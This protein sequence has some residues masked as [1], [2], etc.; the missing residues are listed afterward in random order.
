[1]EFAVCDIDCSEF[2]LCVAG[3][4]V[5]LLLLLYQK[6][7]VLVKPRLLRI[8]HCIRII[9]RRKAA[10]KR[11]VK[12]AILDHKENE[13]NLQM[14]PRGGCG[15]TYV[16]LLCYVN[17]VYPRECDPPTLISYFIELIQLGVQSKNHS[18]IVSETETEEE[19]LFETSKKGGGDKKEKQ[20]LI[21]KNNSAP[22]SIKVL[23]NDLRTP[24]LRN[25]KNS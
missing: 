7:S 13:G 4:G 11:K 22:S 15:H 20:S 14:F 8:S 10:K 5:A 18:L 23:R 21:P 3:R 17:N 6:V 1:M 2:V 25:A 19:I 9:T 12:Y 16:A 24:E